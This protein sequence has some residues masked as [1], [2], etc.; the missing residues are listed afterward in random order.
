MYIVR[1][2]CGKKRGCPHTKPNIEISIA[3]RGPLAPVASSPFY[4]SECCWMCNTFD[5]QLHLYSIILK[6][7][8]LVHISYHKFL[9]LQKLDNEYHVHL[10]HF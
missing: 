4:I 10:Y 7:I 2:S 9:L 3:S 8:V 5:W 1:H 6:A